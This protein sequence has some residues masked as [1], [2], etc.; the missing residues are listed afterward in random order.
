MSKCHIG[1]YDPMDI[2]NNR[3]ISSNRLHRLGSCYDCNRVKAKI[4]FAQMFFALAANIFHIVL[5]TPG[6]LLSRS[7][8]RTVDG[9]L[10]QEHTGLDKF[11]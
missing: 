4:G 2:L 1:A 9:T 10:D 8:I 6:I 7:V 11:P 3:C 5:A